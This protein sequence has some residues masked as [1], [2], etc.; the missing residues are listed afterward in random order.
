MRHEE[1][2]VSLFQNTTGGGGLTLFFGI[3]ATL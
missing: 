1:A 2:A 3:T